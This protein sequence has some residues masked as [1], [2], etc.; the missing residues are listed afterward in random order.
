MLCWTFVA[1]S[2]P[3]CG[4]QLISLDLC[5][6]HLLE[7]ADREEMRCPLSILCLELIAS[8][9]PSCSWPMWPKKHSAEI[10]SGGK[11]KDRCFPSR[12]RKV[13]TWWESRVVLWTEG[14][15]GCNISI[16]T[17]NTSH[18]LQRF[19]F[20]VIWM[21]RCQKESN[22]DSELQKTQHVTACSNTCSKNSQIHCQY[23]VAT[24]LCVSGLSAHLN[25][26]CRWGH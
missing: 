22:R 23:N 3:D 21:L 7:K 26:V 19:Y 8:R 5:L 20:S 9:N 1:D 10:K 18:W 24:L 6:S 17:L 14:Q 16:L 15:E 12:S 2:H 25:N 4:R 13:P 11:Y